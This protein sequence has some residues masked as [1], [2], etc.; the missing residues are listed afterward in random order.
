MSGAV[1]GGQV[2]AV[3]AGVP[4]RLAGR[5][6][7]GEAELVPALARLDVADTVAVVREWVRHAEA[8]DETIADPEPERRLHASRTLGGVGVLD[9]VLDPDG[10]TVVETALRVARR[11][12]PAAGRCPVRS[13]A[14][15]N[16]DA[17]VDLS[18]FFLDH[19]DVVGRP[20]RQ[21]PHLEVVF[22]VADLYG[23]AVAGHGL[24]HLT[25]EEFLAEHPLSPGEAAFARSGRRSAAA[26]RRDHS[27]ASPCGPSSPTPSRATRWSTGCSPT[28]PTSSTTAGACG[29]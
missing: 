7:E 8:L 10:Y 16:A 4:A 22:D 24:D 5:F 25:L 6:A 29:S 9:A 18:R 1:T 28:A 23:A 21:R 14:E 2:E 12:D 26:L 15:R 17:L 3:V 20:G 13:L 27:T 11:D 19:V